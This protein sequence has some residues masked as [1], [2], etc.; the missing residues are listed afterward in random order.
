[1]S[2][3][4]IREV[5]FW[6]RRGL[7]QITL[8]NAHEYRA[9]LDSGTLGPDALE[10]TIEEFRQRMSRTQR[11]IKVA[12]LDQAILAGVGNLYASELLHRAG[13][14]PLKTSNSLSRL[15]FNRVH[16]AMI[17]TLRA[18]IDHEGSTLADGTYRNAINGEGGYQ[19]HHL[20]YDRKGE[21][22]LS[23]HRAKIVRIVQ[24][25]RSTFYCPRCQKEPLRQNRKSKIE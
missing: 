17:E 10:I 7:G 16:G 2:E 23:C 1:L 11:P 9:K 8:L 18:A 5:L 12:L 21:V 14:S 24:A 4:T 13:V 6:D 25:Q 20:V 22:C 3:S 19:N 15:Q